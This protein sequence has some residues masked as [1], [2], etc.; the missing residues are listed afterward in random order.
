[1][2]GVARDAAGA[3]RGEG[4]FLP[5]RVRRVHR[6]AQ[7]ADGLLVLAETLVRLAEELRDLRGA[8]S[9]ARA[10][11]DAER[12]RGRFLVAPLHPAEQ[13]AAEE[14]ERVVR[15][16]RELRG[17]EGIRLPSRIAVRERD[18]PRR[19][20]AVLLGPLQEAR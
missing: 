3:M 8:A 12:V 18:V 20:A 14:R 16:A 11:R 13:R 2:E 15:R 1:M 10:A 19:E 6:G 5:R 4:A 7:P 17:D 9:P